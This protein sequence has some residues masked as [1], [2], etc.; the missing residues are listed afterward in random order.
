MKNFIKLVPAL[1]ILLFCNCDDKKLKP[2][3]PPDAAFFAAKTI[4]EVGQMV[5]FT[6]K[7]T[8][9][10]IE[11]AWNFGDDSGTTVHSSSEE[12][13]HTY[14]EAGTYTVILTVSNDAGCDSETK[15]NYITVSATDITFNNPAYTDIYITLA[16]KSKTIESGKSVTYCD[17]NV[18]P[19]KIDA[20]T[21]GVN[22]NETQFGLKIEWNDTIDV[23]GGTEGYDLNVSSD[24]FFLKMRN[25]GTHILSP[26]YVNWNLESEIVE[27]IVIPN[28]NVNYGIGYYR[29]YNNTV[30]VGAFQDDP[31]WGSF[32]F[33]GMQFSFSKEE[34]M[35]IELESNL[36]K[37]NIQKIPSIRTNLN[38]GSL[39]PTI[40]IKKNCDIENKIIKL[41]CK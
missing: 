14:T 22:S 28:D 34:N 11:W 1:F 41:Y 29:A 17:V 40:N 25:Y 5:Y 8:N 4:I 30:I 13:S 26:I 15:T 37:S 12:L 16:G 32:W 20:Y 18:L 10:P 31:C 21:N 24:Y 2:K 35:L 39:V 27:S 19:V 7:S 3:I 33:Q 6:D 23:S 9:N 38:Q 36:K